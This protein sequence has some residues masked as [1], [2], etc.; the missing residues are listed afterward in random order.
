MAKGKLSDRTKKSSEYVKKILPKDLNVIEL[1]V[2]GNKVC[3]DMRELLSVA[4]CENPVI[5][6]ECLNEASAHYHYFR[7]IMTDLDNEIESA[8]ET[9]DL[10]YAR[11]KNEFENETS[12]KAKERK[13]MVT[14]KE[15]FLKRKE[16]IKEL[17]LHK[18]YAENA[19]KSLEKACDAL[20]SIL[21]SL[22]KEQRHSG[23]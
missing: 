16:G 18:R 11:R 22:T 8:Q 2:K 3:V 19:H 4:D 17:L 15:N 20:R 7:R 14:Y 12:E 13:V 5:V 23:I 9:F 6:R 10:W 1:I 21:S